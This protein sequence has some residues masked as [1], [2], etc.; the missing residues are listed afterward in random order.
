MAM[1]TVA[2]QQHYHI[3]GDVLRR[4]D[5]QYQSEQELGWVFAGHSVDYA[6]RVSYEVRFRSGRRVIR[7]WLLTFSQ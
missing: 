2:V 5:Y 3:A 4:S 7:H 6:Y 1:L